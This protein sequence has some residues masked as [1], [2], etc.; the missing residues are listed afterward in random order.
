MLSLESSD[1]EFHG[2]GIYT[3]ASITMNSGNCHQ[4]PD[5]GEAGA[6][7]KQRHSWWFHAAAGGGGLMLS[8][9]KS[10]YAKRS[11]GGS[12]STKRSR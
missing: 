10:G 3:D 4:G 6:T 12:V 9:P 11:L 7:G 8:D 5:T 1:W 2:K